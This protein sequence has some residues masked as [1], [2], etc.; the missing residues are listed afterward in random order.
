MQRCSRGYVV[1]VLS[2]AFAATVTQADERRAELDRAPLRPAYTLTFHRPDLQ[3]D[4]VLKS[5]EGA[6]MPSPPAALS[7]WLRVRPDARLSQQTRAAV[8]LF[9]PE[10]ASELRRFDEATF[11]FAGADRG[12]SR[13]WRA[14]FPHDDGALSAGAAALVLTGGGVEPIEPEHVAAGQRAGEPAEVRLERLGG[15]GGGFAARSH[16]RLVAASTRADALDGRAH[17]TPRT[18]DPGFVARGVDSGVA[19]RIEPRNLGPRDLDATAGRALNAVARGLGVD[20]IDLVAT[21]DPRGESAVIHARSRLEHRLETAA[22][23]DP[24]WIDELPNDPATA[25]LAAIAFDRAGTTID[26]L[27]SVL[28]QLDRARPGRENVAPLRARLALVAQLVDVRAEVDLWPHLV[29]CVGSIGL[30]DR[31]EPDSATLGLVFDTEPAAERLA[32]VLPELI[33]RFAKPDAPAVKNA[34][35]RRDVRLAGRRLRVRHDRTRLWLDWG[36]DRPQPRPDAATQPMPGA[37]RAQVLE[38]QRLLVVRPRRV[39][40][41]LHLDPPILAALEAVQSVVWTGAIDPTGRELWDTVRSSGLRSAVARALDVLPLDPPPERSTA[42][43]RD[44]GR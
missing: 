13:R 1:I 7:A 8:A 16:G 44:P 5:F 12:A 19:L 22:R 4:R 2:G 34:D 31:G 25:A 20:T 9:N 21:I 11:E 17:G 24:T 41:R 30:D 38:S 33:A 42:A 37:S 27:L 32:R 28:D 39:A 29:G 18:L 23:I 43:P 3:V 26:A 10:T 40:P 15:R 6:R 14:D 35:A 36:D